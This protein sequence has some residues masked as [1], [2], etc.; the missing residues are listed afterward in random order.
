MDRG[1]SLLPSIRLALSPSGPTSPISQ[2]PSH[3]ALLY[4]P[5]ARWA[6]G[7]SA[8]TRPTVLSYGVVYHWGLSNRSVFDWAARVEDSP[9]DFDSNVAP[10]VVAHHVPA[11]FVSVYNLGSQFVEVLPTTCQWD[12]LVVG[13]WMTM[14]RTVP[15]C[16][17]PAVVFSL[18][19]RSWSP[20]YDTI[21]LSV[22]I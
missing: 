13:I 16:G 14:G 21:L 18:A 4:C 19:N 17:P 1:P 12:M 8:E 15:H 2:P 20:I 5:P 22:P 11:N 3:P 7:S 6:S 9:L 10:L